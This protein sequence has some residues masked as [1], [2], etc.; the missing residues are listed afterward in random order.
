MLQNE[1]MKSL[2]FVLAPLVALGCGNGTIT[3]PTPDMTM[4]MATLG[5]APPLAIDLRRQAR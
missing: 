1:G 2:P 4:A 3:T 5:P